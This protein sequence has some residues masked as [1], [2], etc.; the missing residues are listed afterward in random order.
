MLGATIQLDMVLAVIDRRSAYPCYCLGKGP[1]PLLASVNGATLTGARISGSR[2]TGILGGAAADASRRPRAAG[3]SVTARS[4]A[5]GAL[6]QVDQPL[7]GLLAPAGAEAFVSGLEF[8]CR[9][10]AEQVLSRISRRMFPVAR[11][12]RVRGCRFEVP[13]LFGGPLTAGM[14]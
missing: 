9:R 10:R 12:R 1:G 13:D 8:V 3:A 11:T 6:G 14:N 5:R 4:P 2:F 7:G